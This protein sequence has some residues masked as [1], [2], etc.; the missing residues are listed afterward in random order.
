MAKPGISFDIEGIGDLDYGGI[1]LK[2]LDTLVEEV[3][4]KIVKPE[5]QDRINR[6]TGVTEASI[7][8]DREGFFDPRSTINTIAPTWSVWTDVEWAQVLEYRDG[9]KFSF[10]RKAA[11]SRK[12]KTAINMLVKAR[13]GPEMR[14]L[15]R[16]A[17]KRKKAPRK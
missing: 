6:I 10:M 14:A 9:G 8:V 4:K 17:K 3:A 7:E 13:F 15:V 5:V 11:K 16:N 2:V 12:L 1:T